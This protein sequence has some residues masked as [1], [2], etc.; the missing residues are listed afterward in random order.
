MA[1]IPPFFVD[2]VVAIGV[3]TVQNGNPSKAWIGTAD[4]PHP[5]YG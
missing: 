1:L 5:K 4:I 2:C 3:Q